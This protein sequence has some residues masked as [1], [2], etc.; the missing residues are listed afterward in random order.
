[1]FMETTFSLIG[2]YLKKRIF[3]PKIYKKFI[4][5]EKNVALYASVIYLYGLFADRLNFNTDIHLYK[6]V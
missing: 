3:T 4:T 6:P 5:A 2:I 1:M